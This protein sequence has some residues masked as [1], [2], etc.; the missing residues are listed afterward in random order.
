[1]TPP[2]HS[3]LVLQAGRKPALHPS[4]RKKKGGTRPPRGGRKKS[5]SSQRRGRGI[6]VCVGEIVRMIDLKKRERIN[7]ENE[8]SIEG[9]RSVVK[10]NCENDRPEKR[11]SMNSENK[12]SIEEKLEEYRGKL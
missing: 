12:S 7:S 6:R 5:S 3:T 1:M 10:R 8:S 11:K 4:D 9:I 2:I